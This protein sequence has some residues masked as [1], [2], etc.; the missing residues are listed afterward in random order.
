MSM[1]GIGFALVLSIGIWALI[2][3]GI[4]YAFA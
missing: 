1:R 3:L 2:A 4:Y